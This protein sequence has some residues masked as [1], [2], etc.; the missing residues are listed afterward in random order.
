[1]IAY[2][3]TNVFEEAVKRVSFI[4]DN[5]EHVIVSFSGGKDS[6]VVYNLCLREAERRGR[7]PLEVLFIDQEAEWQSTI[8]YV[9]T[10]MYDKRVKP[11]WLQVPIRLFNA[12]SHE[13]DNWL[14]CWAEDEKWIRDKDPIA[15]KENTFGTDRFKE[16][17][18]A[19]IRTTYPD[20]LDKVC[21]V[22]GVRVEESPSRKLALTQNASYKYI[23]WGKKEGKIHAFYPIYDWS[24]T[25]VWHAIA[26]NRWKYN[27][28][29]DEFYKRGVK[30]PNMRVSNLN[31]ETA[32]RS[33][34][35]IQE[36]EP[37]TWNKIANRMYGINTSTKMDFRDLFTPP[38]KLPF[39]FKDWFE[40]RDHLLNNL[41]VDPEQRAT[42]KHEFD[43]VDQLYIGSN[44]IMQDL[45]KCEISSILAN[46]YTFTKLRTF[47]STPRAGAY[48]S[49]IKGR[50]INRVTDRIE[51]AMEDMYGARN[52]RNH[53]S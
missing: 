47:E 12:T 13:S 35:Y 42:F 31:H 11:Y 36:I 8:D 28:V 41:V 17:F 21:T 3:D 37:D 43:R 50:K 24:Y 44:D 5:F 15:I 29:Y 2:K 46:D 6:T 26:K 22:G 51:K 1:M 9:K 18:N 53:E 23:T 30:P 16:M 27:R 40:Y 39:M 49:L 48:R 32:L 25:D 20:E 38:K 45:V 4:F 52:Q 33:L 14:H 10:V 7:L 19:F 34:Q